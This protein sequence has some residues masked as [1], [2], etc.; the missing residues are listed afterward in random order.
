MIK[1]IVTFVLLFIAIPASADL[2]SKLRGLTGYNIVDNKIIVGWYEE[3]GDK[4]DNF[5]GCN[6]D[7]VIVFSDNK[8]LRCE[9]YVYQ[10]RYKPTA[11]ILSNGSQFKMIVGDEIY[12]M[13]R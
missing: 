7:R 8:I 5:E 6:Y 9:E 13:S 12:N 2:T 3:S 11:I 4:G 1:L 10:Y